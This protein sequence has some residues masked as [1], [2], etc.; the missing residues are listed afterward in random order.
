M[1]WA[2]WKTSFSEKKKQLSYFPW[3]HLSHWC[4]CMG[5][6]ASLHCWECS[7]A[8]SVPVL[9]PFQNHQHKQFREPNP[10]N[11]DPAAHMLC[12]VQGTLAQESAG[13]QVFPNTSLKRLMRVGHQKCFFEAN[14]V[15]GTADFL[16]TLPRGKAMFTTLIPKGP[17]SCNGLF[18]EPWTDRVRIRFVS[19]AGRWGGQRTTRRYKQTLWR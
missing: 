9:G 16:G 17:V 8:Q 2:L 13:R 5:E 3:K 10:A 1:N 11:H 15:C 6:F 18:H 14:R 7:L 4:Y 12:P 19:S